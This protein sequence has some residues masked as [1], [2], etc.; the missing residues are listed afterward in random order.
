MKNEVTWIKNPM[1]TELRHGML[2][3]RDEMTHGKIPMSQSLARAEELIVSMLGSQR[4]GSKITIIAAD[5]VHGDRIEIVCG[6]DDL[7]RAKKLP[8]PAESALIGFEFPETDGLIATQPGTVLIIQTADCLPILYWDPATG[9]VGACHCGWKGVYAGLARKT[10]EAMIECGARIESLEAWIAPGICA[11][12]YEVGTE[13]VGK[14]QAVFPD[15]RVT[16]NGTH[17]DLSAVATHQLLRAGIAPN[18]ITD[19]GRCTFA[20]PQIFHSYR[21]E[22]PKAGRLLTLICN[23]AV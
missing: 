12:N 4:G 7:D 11:M 15:A 9:I 5:Q 13:L 14:F 23:W 21:R 3:R 17:L 22:G 6:A 19:S 18:H 20:E 16:P 10:A 2:T 8:L 1:W